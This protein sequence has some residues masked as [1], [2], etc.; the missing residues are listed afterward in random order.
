MPREKYVMTVPPSVRH[1]RWVG[2]HDHLVVNLQSVGDVRAAGESIS[3]SRGFAEGTEAGLERLQAV[4]VR[5]CASAEDGR[6][7]TVVLNAD[8]EV[9]WTLAGAV[10]ARVLNAPVRAGRLLWTVDVE[11]GFS[12]YQEAVVTP[13]NAP[14]SGT[15]IALHPGEGRAA[16]AVGSETRPRAEPASW[17]E[18]DATWERAAELLGGTDPAS[19]PLTLE[20]DDDV[21]WADVVGVFDLALGAGLD[22]VDIPA[23]GVRFRLLPPRPEAPQAPTLLWSPALVFLCLVAAL[24]SFAVT[25]WPLAGMG[26]SRPTR[27]STPAP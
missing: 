4:L 24:L 12:M 20:V 25:W 6:C 5:A 21:R 7:A 3:L 27:R 11:D 22:R 2:R 14:E 17:K 10:L 9:S 23:L 8:L 13:A 16:I 1:A 18:A 26:R 15:R 19:G